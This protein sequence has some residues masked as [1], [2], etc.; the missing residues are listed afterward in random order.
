[1]R[2]A[3]G[4][5]SHGLEQF[6][7]SDERCLVDGSTYHAEVVVKA[8]TFDFACDSIELKSAIGCA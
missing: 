7:L 5:A 3:Y 2:C 6:H 8:D 4:I 1:M